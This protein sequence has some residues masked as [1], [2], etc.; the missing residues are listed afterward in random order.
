MSIAIVSVLTANDTDVD[1]LLSDFGN[2]SVL[3]SPASSGYELA[4]AGDN[5]I[6]FVTGSGLTYSGGRPSG[7]T[8]FSITINASLTD[9]DLVTLNFLTGISASAFDAAMVQFQGGDRTAFDVLI[10]NY[11]YLFSGNAGKDTFTGYVGNEIFE[12]GAGADDFDGGTGNNTLSYTADTAGVTVNLSN[13]TASGGHAQ[14]DTFANIQNLN[15]GSGN[16]SLTGDGGANILQGNKGNDFFDGGAGADTIDGGEGVDN[17]Y[18]GTSTAGVT[19][20]LGAG[21]AQTIG[22]GGNAEGDKISNIETVQGTDQGADV[23]TGNELANNFYGAQG[24]DKLDGGAG[25]DFL[26]GGLGADTLIGGAGV[27]TVYYGQDVVGVTI[28]LG[29][30]GAQTIGHGGSAEG[31][32]ISLVEKI[33]GSSENDILTGNNLANFIFGS[34][35]DDVIQGGAG[36]DGLNGNGG[37]DTLSYAASL[38]AVTVKINSA[39]AGSASGGDAQGDTIIEFENLTGGSGNDVLSGDSTANI[40]NGGAGNDTIDGGGGSDKLDGGVGINTISYA[41]VTSVVAVILNDVPG[42]QIFMSNA[43][44]TNALFNFQNI[45]GTNNLAGGDDLRGNS[46]ANVLQGLDGDDYLQGLGGNDTLIGGNGADTFVGGLGAD[47][48]IGGAGIDFVDYSDEFSTAGGITIKLG[49]G[50]AQSIQS[51]GEAQNDKLS[52]VEN[53]NGSIFD[54]VLVGNELGNYFSGNAGNDVIEGGAGADVLDGGPAGSDTVSYASSSA[55]VTIIFTGVGIGSVGDGGDAEDD[56]IGNFENITGS[57]FGDI[58]KGDEG[59]NVI[60]G[61]AGNDLIEGRLGGDT[62]KGGTGNDTLSYAKSSAAVTVQLLGAKNADTSGGDATADAVSGFE[63]IIGSDNGDTLKGDGGANII[64]GGLGDDVLDGGAGTNDTVSYAGSGNP[65]TVDLTKTTQQD[66]V[67]AGKD[68]ITGFENIIGSGYADSLKGTGGANNI[69]GG[70]GDDTIEGGAGADTLDGGSDNE[71]TGDVL[72][73]ANSTQG[74]IVTLGAAGGKTTGSGGDAKGDVISNFENILG[75]SGNDVLTGNTSSNKI[76]GGGGNDKV[77]GRGMGGDVLTGGFGDDIVEGSGFGDTLDGGAETTAGD[78]LSYAL[79]AS[80][81]TVN[82]FTSFVQQNGFGDII[83]GFENIA[84]SAKNDVLTGDNGS[85]KIDGGA[86]DD[87]IEGLVGADILIG[88]TGIDT[89]SYFQSATSVTV[90]LSLA[91]AQVSTGDADGDVL[92]GFENILGAEAVSNILTGDKNNNVIEGGSVNDILDGGLGNNTVSYANATGGV[93]ISLAAQGGAQNTIN[94]GTDT[95]TNFQ[96]FIGSAYGDTLTGDAK[97]NIIKGGDGDDHIEG[98]LGADILDGG[99]DDDTAEYQGSSA[100]VTIML[101]KDGAQTKGAGGEAAGDRISNIENINGSAKDDV[102]TGNNL[103]NRILGSTGNDLIQGG[104]GNDILSGGGDAHDTI[105]YAASSAGVTIVITDATQTS[106]IGGD[107]QGDKISG[108]QDIIGSAKDD[109]LTGSVSANILDG[110]AGNDILAGGQGADT[111]KGNTGIDT[112]NYTNS[113]AGVTVALMLKTA[114]TSTGDA[115]GDILSGIENLIGAATFA[116]TLSGD[117][118]A[119][120]ITGGSAGD[121]LNGGAGKDTVSY[122]NAS[123]KVTVDL[124]LTGAQN[125]GTAGMDNL[126]GFENLTGGSNDDTLYG[127]KNANVILGGTGNDIIEGRLGADMLDGGIG[128]D[129]LSYAG[130]TKAVT[131]ALGASGISTTGKGGDSAGDKV[132]NFENI[133]GSAFADNLKGNADDNVIK[134]GAGDD[135]IEG[136]AGG[137]NLDGEGGINTLS[138]ASSAA[139]VF[140][141]LSGGAVNGGD[142]D[143]DTIHNFQNLIGSAKDDILSG[144]GSANKFDGGAGNDAIE[145]AGGNDILIGGIGN[146]TV[147]YTQ[148]GTGVTVSLAQTKQQNTIGAGLDTLS[149]FENLYGSDQNDVLTGNAGNNII[150]GLEGDDIIDGG[151]GND[152]LIGSNNGAGGDTVSY[153]SATGAVTVNILTGLASGAAGK[154]AVIAFEHIIGGKGGDTLT[155]T[156]GANTINGGAG[157]DVI[158]G[159]GGADTLIGGLGVN[160]VSYSTSTTGVDIDLTVQGHGATAPTNPQNS[161]DAA[162]DLLYDFQNIIG[163]AK[164]DFLIGDAAINKIDGGGGNDRISGGAGADTLDGGDGFDLLDYSGTSGSVTIALGAP[165]IQTTGVGSDAAGDKV[166]NFEGVIGSNFNDQL[167]GNAFDNLLLG[168]VGAD[169][170]TGGGGADTFQFLTA[171]QG[172]DTIVD[173]VSGTDLIAI[174]KNG[175]QGGLPGLADGPLDPSYFVTGAGATSPDNAHGYFEFDTTTHQLFWDMDGAGGNAHELIATFGANVTLTVND[176]ILS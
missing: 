81:V 28:T 122:A 173:F 169:K 50:G 9:T 124:A 70:Q 167:T 31:D 170:L 171:A 107:A 102:L 120:I 160:T 129:T 7:G 165:N 135:T 117:G 23:L 101:G 8:I 32:K 113:S 42:S 157:N 15:G 49:K 27:D 153:A 147:M 14:G 133:T 17:A 138:Y 118:A 71:A 106:G 168:G 37:I 21:G 92:S 109:D 150:I 58:L 40:I 57:A 159:G 36:A 110:G 175:F 128:L 143:L 94:A 161:G 59:V 73:Y 93:S 52:E 85:N 67:G 166:K 76:D 100:A 115:S 61:L 125:T 1:A 69:A 144:N 72:S 4:N 10:G 87:L 172:N 22:K 48:I 88:N 6:F 111:L 152:E 63:N 77:V 3:Q 156:G 33:E 104:A 53:V 12:G 5:L 13:S 11:D 121:I 64:E 43:F 74:V 34:D 89:V 29:T 162:G 98:G 78:T 39:G 44:F 174:A 142:A 25:D 99:A 20:K 47:T 154:D 108:F 146:D 95:L 123:G 164:A 26:N 30:N 131:I 56:S 148:A 35:G 163:S 24:A 75:G 86:G 96:N 103:S 141:D 116:N 149:G 114:Q 151:A 84:G 158:E 97:V 137:D 134:G 19:I 90:N 105:S 136:G 91:T 119:N 45:T 38:A 51:G 130:S 68:T 145:G 60:D 18:Y 16:D 139:G 83:A 2:P 112:A 41:S 132:K 65:V 55:G 62:L 126:S 127:D 46:L 79:L 155:G 176:F 54:D 66:T 82:L 80:G 140:I